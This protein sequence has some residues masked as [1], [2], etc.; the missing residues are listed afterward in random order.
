MIMDCTL[1]EYCN[2]LLTLGTSNRPAGISVRE[3]PL[4]Y[5]G[6]R[7]PDSSVFERL[8]KRLRVT[9]NV[10]P[11]AHVNEAPPTDCMNSSQ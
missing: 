4:Y 8:E 9:G 2:M 5:P 1:D 11:T 3:H 6:R 10:T 7:H